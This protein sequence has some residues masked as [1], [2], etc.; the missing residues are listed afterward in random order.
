MKIEINGETREI[1]ANETIKSVVEALNIDD[2]IAAC[3]LD[4]R[5]VK[6]EFWAST[7][8]KEGDRLELLT[9]VGGGGLFDD[10]GIIARRINLY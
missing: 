10:L 4:S 6:R 9:F 1:K 5:I 8:L 2:K 3:A 7:M